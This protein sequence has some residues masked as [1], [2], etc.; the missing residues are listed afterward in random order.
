MAQSLQ[1]FLFARTV[2]WAIAVLL[3]EGVSF[4]ANPLP[5]CLL[6]VWQTEDGLPDNKVMAVAQ[7]RDGYIWAGTYSGLARFDGLHFTVFDNS[8][9]REMHSPQVTS[10]FASDDGTLWIGHANGEITSY[11]GGI[12]R[13][14]PVKAAWDG[15][16]ILGMGADAQGDFWLV[17]ED[18]LLA[19]QRDGLV[20]TPVAGNQTNLVAMARSATGTIWV[21]RAGQ[22]S[23]LKQGRLETVEFAGDAP[24][25]YLQGI[26][27]SCKGELWALTDRRIHKQVGQTWAEALDFAPWGMSAV[28]CLLEA[29]EGYFAAA[30]SDQGLFLV[31]HEGEWVRYCR[32]NGF[33]ID[34]V[35]SVCQDREGNLWVGTGGGGLVELR[36]S[37]IENVAPPDRWQARAVLAVQTASDG[38]L[39]VGTEGAGLYRYLEGNWNVYHGQN[40]LANEYI[41]SIAEDAQ[42]QIWAGTWGGGL[43]VRQG[44]QFR[45]AP[46]LETFLVPIPA[47]LPA[48]A[49]GLWVGT[50]VGLM[51]Y[52]AGKI[53]WFGQSTSQPLE[54]IRALVED[55][56]GGVWVGM[57]GGGL[58]YLKNGQMRSF[59][60]IDGLSSDFVQCLYQE[61]NGVLW[62]GTLGGGLT[63]VKDEQLTA[64][65]QAQGLANMVTC[66]I[67]EDDQGCFWIGSHD[68][69]MRVSKA[70]LNDCADG[71]LK[72]IHCLSCGRSDGLPTL[73]CSGGFQPAGCKTA[74]GR[75]WL[76]T[77]KGLVA[78][79]PRN[80]SSN[81]LPPLVVLEQ[82]LVDGQPVAVVTADDA[83]L[84]IGPGRNQL[85]F[86]YTALSFIA[87]ERIRFKYRLKGLDRDWTDAGT[88]RQAT[89]SY[90]PPGDYTFEA[91][92]CN[93]DGVW[94]E[95]GTAV[96]FTLLPHWW[97]TW[98][99][100]AAC[101]AGLSAALAGLV[102]YDTRRRMRRKLER[103]ERQRAIEH[104]RARIA[105][106]IHDDLGASLTRI[107]MLSQVGR[108]E[109]ANADEA[110]ANLDHIC[111]T[112]RELTSAMDEIVWAVNPLHDTLDSLATYLGKFGQDFLRAARIRC[113]L[114]LP[115][116]LPAW[117]L[118]SEQRHNLFL[119]YKEALHNVVKHSR[120][121]EVRVSLT[122]QEDGFVL[123]VQDNGCGLGSGL[124]RTESDLNSVRVASGNGLAN[125]RLR[126]EEIR[127]QCEIS[128]EAGGG[129]CVEFRVP[130]KYHS[131][132]R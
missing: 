42:G 91:T 117:P 48:R 119:A 112:A 47:L 66:S 69:I 55:R 110:T 65:G 20:L 26:G 21:A 30:T 27:A 94:N 52:D 84:R 76:P 51:R 59:R 122:L 104:E 29:R 120:A 125:M 17:N 35:T 115:V 67:L 38:A 14:V 1:P 103:L 53:S 32:T 31:S 128:S 45:R 37:H 100:R 108:G 49:G 56:Q 3:V 6:R 7:T 18:G 131:V 127:G 123:S 78:L 19:R 116:E 90:I 88:L 111:H 57:L 34:W 44:E 73:Q 101:I 87:S 72:T 93:R 83:P 10:L 62:V 121:S 25:V 60:K 50:G 63:R 89:Y 71:K 64:I 43:F 41:W 36:K 61:T 82:M 74:D 13:D 113:F 114:L 77:A 15:G 132:A 80:V 5:H 70:E 96:A 99:F 97:Q 92:A 126:L 2:H 95:T 81:T 40:G 28:H 118:S 129:T 24:T 75:L 79:N 16:K 106:D 68:G 8:N 9:T 54:D 107:T 4:A 46:G 58:V 109:F 85:D 105:K 23:A 11:K 86:R 22:I 102:W 98:W 12:F 39:W 124:A 33:P 130:L